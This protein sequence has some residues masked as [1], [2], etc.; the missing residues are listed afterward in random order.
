MEQHTQDT[1]SPEPNA[2]PES[3]TPHHRQRC[4]ARRRDRKQ[5][6]LFVQ[7]P[8]TGLCARH[9][10]CAQRD[11]A[12]IDDS[13]NISLDLL[14][15]QMGALDSTHAI[16]I[17]LTNVVIMLA[18]GRISPRRASVITFALSLM[19]RSVVV[20]DRKAASTPP[21][22]IFDA[23]GPD[24]SP[25]EPAGSTPY[26]Q[27]TGAQPSAN[28]SPGSTPMTSFEAAEKYARMRT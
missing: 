3:S 19:L 22:I 21:E 12:T 2:S 26:H 6:R 14:D 20:M 17:V 16:N 4:R 28:A 5:C 23:P 27:E 8:A 25:N 15:S 11:A 9:A 10:A 13:T 7:D 1:V 24:D 18:Q